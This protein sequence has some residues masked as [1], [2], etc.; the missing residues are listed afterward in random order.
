MVGFASRGGPGWEPCAYLVDHAVRRI[1]PSP[2][3]WNVG[4]RAVLPP[5]GSGGGRRANGVPTAR[6]PLSSLAEGTLDFGGG[7]SGNLH[8]YNYERD[9][10]LAARNALRSQYVRTQVQLLALT[11]ITTS[12]VA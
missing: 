4:A 10:A 9:V 12:N 11:W 2:K 3:V 1:V 8:L 7:F 5:P 6:A